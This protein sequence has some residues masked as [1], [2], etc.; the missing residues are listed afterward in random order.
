MVNED[1]SLF[2]GSDQVY[3]QVLVPTA[4]LPTAL[5]ALSAEAEV[6]LVPHPGG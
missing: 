6:T 2:T 1:S 3:F 4:D 5:A